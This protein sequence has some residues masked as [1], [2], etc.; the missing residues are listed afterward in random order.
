MALNEFELIRRYFSDFSIAPAGAGN[1]ALG[2][3][4]DGAII[5]VAES[6][7]LVFSIDTQLAGVHFPVDADPAAIAQRAFRCAISDLAAMG[8]EP[9][10]FTLAL[11]LPTAN[12]TWLA[13]FSRGLKEAANIFHCP[14]VGGDTTKGPL[15]ITLQ[16]HG[17]VPAGTALKR[18]GAKV[19]D[20]ILVSGSLGSSA[21]YVELMKQNR[22]DE[23]SLAHAVELFSQ[24]YFFPQIPITLG[25][26]LRNHARSALDISDGLLADLTHL[27]RASKINAEIQLDKLPLLP[28]LIATF[29]HGQATALALSGGDDYQ[30]C[31]TAPENKVRKILSLSED[32]ECPVT[33]IGRMLDSPFHSGQPVTCYTSD[34]KI[35][36]ITTLNASGYTHF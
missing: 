6:C 15:C 22:L 26:A 35:F 25:K 8:A 17:T 28:E 32:M 5:Q 30:L 12:E 10:C 14:L 27:C 2:T 33:V 36:D 19:G 9:M 18:S 3:G 31:F 16:V 7:E 21:A 11:T 34:G 4:D 20:I 13:S 23:K 1:I 24:D 29:G